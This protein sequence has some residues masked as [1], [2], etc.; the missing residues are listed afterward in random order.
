MEKTRTVVRICGQEFRLTATESEEYIQKIA[1][2]VDKKVEEVQK[3]YPG[4]STS[5]CVLLAALNLSDELHQTKA[6]YEALDSRID[7]LRNIPRAQPDH[8]VPV[9]RP[10]ENKTPV[11]T[12]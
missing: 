12:K 3:A 9:K 11:G 7:Q 6:N 1:I 8:A 5:N 4:L 10:F 2:Y